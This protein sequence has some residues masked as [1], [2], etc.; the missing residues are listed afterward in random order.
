VKLSSR[1]ERRDLL[2]VASPY[3]VS[4]S[5]EDGAGQ[6]L[7]ANYRFSYSNNIVNSAMRTNSP[8]AAWRK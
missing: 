2:F 3:V 7:I 5:Q 8:F 4:F 6:L 1:P